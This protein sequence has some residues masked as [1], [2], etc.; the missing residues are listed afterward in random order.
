V[1]DAN[2]T[3]APCPTKRRDLAVARK[4]TNGQVAQ[5]VTLASAAGKRPI[6]AVMRRSLPRLI[7][8]DQCLSASEVLTCGSQRQRAD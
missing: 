2:K 3:L 8:K 1:F 7:D 5:F 6:L 4:I